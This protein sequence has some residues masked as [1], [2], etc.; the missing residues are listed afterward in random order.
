[1]LINSLLIKK[2]RVGADQSRR[3]D[4]KGQEEDQEAE[5]LGSCG[6][7]NGRGEARGK[8]GG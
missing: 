1:M 7:V 5:T 3:H 6:R 4:D 8:E 2:K